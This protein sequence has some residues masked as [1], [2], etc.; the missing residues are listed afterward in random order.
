[1]F[2]EG[3][4]GGHH[5]FKC[6][7]TWVIAFKILYSN[8]F[9][10]CSTSYRI[11]LLQCLESKENYGFTRWIDPRPIYPHRRYIY[12]LQDRIFDLEME[13]SSG[14]KDD[15]DE[16]NNNGADSQEALCND[17]YCTCPNHKNNGPPPPPLPPPPTTM[18]GYCGEGAT[19]FAMWPHY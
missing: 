9:L 17:Q 12:Y 2:T 10:D 5:F 11:Y 3:L 8:L 13:V 18:G 1:M 19:Q 15:K 7:R 14:Y 6:P 16:D 4:D